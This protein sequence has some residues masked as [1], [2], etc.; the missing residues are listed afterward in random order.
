[1][2][3]Y[4]ARCCSVLQCVTVCVAV[5]VAVCCSVFCRVLQFVAVCV[6]AFCNMSQG[7]A[8]CCSALQRVENRGISIGVTLM[9]IK[10]SPQGGKGKQ[11]MIGALRSDALYIGVMLLLEGID[12]H[13]YIY[14][15]ICIY[16]CIYMNIHTY[17]YL[18]IYLYICIYEY[19]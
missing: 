15:Y 7:V 10:S 17:M 16:I 3:Q 12:M 2:L 8:F 11:K 6:A 14:I 4:A 5:C 18:Y 13:L 9:P 19:T 1:V